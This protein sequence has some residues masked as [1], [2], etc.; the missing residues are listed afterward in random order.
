MIAQGRLRAEGLTNIEFVHGDATAMPYPDS[1]FD[2]VL[3]A[4]GLSVLS[5]SARG[6]CLAEIRRV[7]KTPGRL[8]VVDIDN[9][10]HRRRSLDAWPTLLHRRCAPDVSG[11]GLLRL[12]ESR[13]FRP[14]RHLSGQGGLL[15]FQII[16]AHR[17]TADTDA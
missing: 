14:I 16:V 9:P 6:Q 17:A 3:V 5:F 8:L 12:I 11:S 15:P 7:L 13:G 4:F 1:Y 2:L 10:L